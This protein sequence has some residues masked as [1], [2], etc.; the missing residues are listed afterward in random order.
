MA[1][2]RNING[3]HPLKEKAI[4]SRPLSAR[5]RGNKLSIVIFGSCSGLSRTREERHWNS[6]SATLHFSVP[7]CSACGEM[8]IIEERIR[9]WEIMLDWRLSR[10]Q[11]VFPR[12]F[13]ER[14]SLTTTILRGKSS[15]CSVRGTCPLSK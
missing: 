13:L 10:Q 9:K 4:K 8:S 11:I 14:T 15:P 2:F 1:G 12:F 6:I 5:K 3:E 7:I